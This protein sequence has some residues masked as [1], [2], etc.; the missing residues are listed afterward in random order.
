MV[1]GSAGRGGDGI[2]E[3]DG[4]GSAVKDD[5]DYVDDGFNGGGDNAVEDGLMGKDQ[6]EPKDVSFTAEPEIK[7]VIQPARRESP[8]GKA[9]VNKDPATVIF[10][11]KMEK[12]HETEVKEPDVL[13][14]KDVVIKLAAK[15]SGLLENLAVVK[16][17]VIQSKDEALVTMDGDADDWVGERDDNCREMEDEGGG[18]DAVNT[19]AS[20]EV[21]NVLVEDAIRPKSKS[22]K[23]VNRLKDVAP[24]V[25]AVKKFA[26]PTVKLKRVEARA[27]SKAEVCLENLSVKENV[28]EDSDGEEFVVLLAHKDKDDL[29]LP[30]KDVLAAA[31]IQARHSKK[32]LK[33]FEDW[34]RTMWKVEIAMDSSNKDIKGVLAR[35]VTAGH[36]SSEVV[37]EEPRVSSIQEARLVM[38]T[39]MKTLVSRHCGRRIVE[40]EDESEDGLVRTEDCIGVV[41]GLRRIRRSRDVLAGHSAPV[42]MCMLR[43]RKL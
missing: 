38:K 31:V 37:R 42:E 18:N 8:N 16:S 26:K 28:G 7:S 36:V 19:E 34:I 2:K 3:P 4:D 1:K 35:D 32:E 6:L 24:E 23:P 27:K 12:A 9:E 33:D 39:K 13:S 21:T 15:K 29:K 11:E 10:E 17:V 30:K 40:K 20:L 25:V 5:G 14:S 41:V 22:V 43:T